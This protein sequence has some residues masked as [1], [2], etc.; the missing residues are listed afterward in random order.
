MTEQLLL[1]FPRHLQ[2]AYCYSVQKIFCICKCRLVSA[3]TTHYCCQSS[4]HSQFIVSNSDADCSSETYRA[5]WLL[6]SIEEIKLVVRRA[7][8]KR[9]DETKWSETRD[10]TPR[11][12]RRRP[13]R[14]DSTS[15]DGRG[16]ETTSVQQ[17]RR[18]MLRL[19]VDA[20]WWLTEML[21]V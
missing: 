14:D 15:R 19:R 12:F 3:F 8:T 6:T 5:Y 1:S 9:I 17:R 21:V 11:P 4:M 18:A 10:E 7:C 16:T 20:R 13:R 2:W